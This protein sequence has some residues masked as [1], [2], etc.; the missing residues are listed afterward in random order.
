MRRSCRTTSWARRARCTT[1][2]AAVWPRVF[3]LLF[4]Y[5]VDAFDTVIIHSLKLYHNLILLSAEFCIEAELK[6]ESIR[7][8]KFRIAALEAAKEGR[9]P[10]EEPKPKVY[11]NQ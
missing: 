4:L 6:A 8:E 1:S 7:K 11:R 5:G 2:S 9:V 3:F 10:E